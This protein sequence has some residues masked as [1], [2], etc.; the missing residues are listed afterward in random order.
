MASFRKTGS[1]WRAEL[2]VKGRR[3]SRTFDTKAE[4][5]AWALKRETEL[6][7]ISGGAG[8]KTHTVGDVFARLSR[9]DKPDEARRAL[10]KTQA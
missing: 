9:Q 2:Y 5:Q 4:A 10:G 3:D 8:S 7:S 1:G 6:R